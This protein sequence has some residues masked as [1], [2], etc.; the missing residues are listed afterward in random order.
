MQKLYVTQ[1]DPSDAVTLIML[2][3]GTT[4]RAE[5]KHRHIGMHE[6][7]S[8]RCNSPADQ[9]GNTIPALFCVTTPATW[10]ALLQTPQTSAF[11]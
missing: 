9:L 4:H 11:P 5:V 3:L 2:L 6:F 10:Q 1:R 8:L 7:C